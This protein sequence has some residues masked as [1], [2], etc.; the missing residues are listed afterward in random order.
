[1]DE[2]ENMKETKIEIDRQ[3]Q[4]AIMKFFLKTSIPRILKNKEEKE[5]NL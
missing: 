1:M 3:T 5:N 2:K 4:I